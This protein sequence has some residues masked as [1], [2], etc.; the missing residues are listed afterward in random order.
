MVYFSPEPEYATASLPW[1]CC[2]LALAQNLGALWSL[3]LHSKSFHCSTGLAEK[4][5][6]YY[7]LAGFSSSWFF[8][9][10][11]PGSCRLGEQIDDTQQISDSVALHQHCGMAYPSG[12]SHGTPQ[13]THN[14]NPKLPRGWQRL[15]EP[16]DLPISWISRGHAKSQKGAFPLPLLVRKS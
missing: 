14:W 5:L 8:N 12:D 13:Y 7:A 6:L 15:C 9:I 11:L 2:L 3:S 1:H 10:I 16:E 4:R